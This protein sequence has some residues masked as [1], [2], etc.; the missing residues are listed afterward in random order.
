MKTYTFS[1]YELS[2]ITTKLRHKRTSWTTTT[3]LAFFQGQGLSE[4]TGK[5]G[6]LWEE[7][8]KG[9]GNGW[10]DGTLPASLR[11]LAEVYES[12]GFGLFS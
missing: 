7:T 9:K 2:V 3:S 8:G 10:M 4:R 11:A 1:D 5:Q 6:N 12:C